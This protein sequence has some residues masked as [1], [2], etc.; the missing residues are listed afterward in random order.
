MTTINSG[1]RPDAG[2]LEAAR[3]LLERLGV[4]PADLLASPSQRP[5]I[6]A[7]CVPGFE[8]PAF[9]EYEIPRGKTRIAHTLAVAR[10]R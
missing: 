5:A 9:H 4:S 3:L 10:R 7:A 1:S 2:D 6:E 8:P